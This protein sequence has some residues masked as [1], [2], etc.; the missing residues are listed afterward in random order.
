MKNKLA[1]HKR[2]LSSPVSK[3]PLDT[4]N[5]HGQKYIKIVL[6]AL[7]P[8]WFEITLI[9]VKVLWL[10]QCL[11]RKDGMEWCQ[12]LNP[13]SYKLDHVRLC[14]SYIAITT[15]SKPWT[16]HAMQVMLTFINCMAYCFRIH[17]QMWYCQSS[18]IMSSICMTY[19]FLEK[20]YF[21]QIMASWRHYRGLMSLND[22]VSDSPWPSDGFVKRVGLP[23][24]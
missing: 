19:S 9:R 14:D 11:T 8:K 22:T 3:V 21:G 15:S 17:C 24:S 18:L 23:T 7:R 12:S 5:S 10:L 1:H 20:K 2:L 13:W 16:I 4:V 6:S